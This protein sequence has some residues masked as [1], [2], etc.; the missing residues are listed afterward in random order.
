[1]KKLLRFALLALVVVMLAPNVRP[2]V[3]ESNGDP[4]TIRTLTIHWVYSEHSDFGDW[5]DSGDFDVTLYNGDS[6][7][8][9]DDEGYD[10][11]TG[12]VWS[13]S[14]SVSGESAASW[15]L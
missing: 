12:T 6:Y 10:S 4:S 9:D 7:D 15:A 8:S 3:H 2:E 14:E 13:Y 5:E 1:M 11:S